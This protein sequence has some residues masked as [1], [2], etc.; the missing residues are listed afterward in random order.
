[1]TRADIMKLVSLIEDAICQRVEI[2][3]Y[4]EILPK[5]SEV[6]YN[7]YCIINPE[8]YIAVMKDKKTSTSVIQAR[9][10]IDRQ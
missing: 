1:M 5:V 9:Q 8:Y 7:R 2:S 3:E 4:E 10:R 6:L